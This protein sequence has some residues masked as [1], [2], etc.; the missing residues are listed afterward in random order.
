MFQPSSLTMPVGQFV[1]HIA[2]LD[3]WPIDALKPILAELTT[4]EKRA[5]VDSYVAASA[6]RSE[7]SRMTDGDHQRRGA[8]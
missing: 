7:R 2:V 6:R 5:D 1:A 8:V 4:H 3:H